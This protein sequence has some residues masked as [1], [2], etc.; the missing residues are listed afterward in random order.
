MYSSSRIRRMGN[1]IPPGST[2]AISSR[3]RWPRLAARSP[4][5]PPGPDFWH[6]NVAKHQPL[7]E[8]LSDITAKPKSEVAEGEP[9]RQPSYAMANLPPE[10]TGLAFLVFISK[11]G[12]AP[13]A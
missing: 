2:L 4:S 8:T 12:G 13:T 1:R 11:K 7:T 5:C 10:R 6:A 3:R 9:E